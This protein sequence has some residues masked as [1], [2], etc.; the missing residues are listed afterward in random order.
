MEGLSM[1][2]KND[3]LVAA[4]DGELTLEVTQDLKENVRQALEETGY[5]RFVLDLSKVNFIDSSGIG[6]L[7]SMASRMKSAGVDFHLYKPSTQVGK[8]LELVQLKNHF[9]TI[10]SERELEELL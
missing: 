7:V 4:Y 8:T 10:D 6:F 2:G 5:S 9:N 3:T 1:D